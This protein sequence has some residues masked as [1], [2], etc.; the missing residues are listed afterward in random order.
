MDAFEWTLLA[1]LFAL[2]G[3]RAPVIDSLICSFP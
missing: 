1:V 2:F 3:R